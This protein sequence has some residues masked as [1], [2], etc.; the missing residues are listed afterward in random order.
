MW[1][2]I[3]DSEKWM[4]DIAWRNMTQY[5]AKHV[6]VKT[7]VLTVGVAKRRACNSNGW[8]HARIDSKA[9]RPYCVF[10]L[11]WIGDH[12][13]RTLLPQR[14]HVAMAQWPCPLIYRCSIPISFHY[15][16]LDFKPKSWVWSWFLQL[17]TKVSKLY[18]LYNV[19]IYCSLVT[20]LVITLLSGVSTVVALKSVSF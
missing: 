20:P 9:I 1:L 15:A 10:L 5:D 14:L 7:R 11:D 3:V 19:H 17:K 6:K 13:I 4:W 16:R 8:N 12:P 18:F 2:L